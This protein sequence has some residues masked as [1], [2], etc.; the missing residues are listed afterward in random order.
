MGRIVDISSIKPVGSVDIQINQTKQAENPDGLMGVDQFL[1]DQEKSLYPSPAERLNQK[2]TIPPEDTSPVAGEYQHSLLYGKDPIFLGPNFTALSTADQS[3]LPQDVPNYIKWARTPDKAEEGFWKNLIPSAEKLPGRIFTSMFYDYPKEVKDDFMSWVEM[4]QK[5]EFQKL[6]TSQKIGAN[7]IAGRKTVGAVAKP[8]ADMIDGYL[9]SSGVYDV[10]NDTVTGKTIFMETQPDGSKSVAFALPEMKEFKQMWKSDPVGTA[11]LYMPFV[12]HTA[13]KKAALSKANA[14]D[15]ALKNAQAEEA[16]RQARETRQTGQNPVKMKNDIL[17]TQAKV[18]EDQG[19]FNPDYIEQTWSNLTGVPKDV[20]KGGESLVQNVAEVP[21]SVKTKRVTTKVKKA[22]EAVGVKVNTEFDLYRSFRDELEKAQSP[23]EVSIISDKYK[24]LMNAEDHETAL[25]HDEMDRTH[26]NKSLDQNL[27]KGEG[28]PLDASTVEDLDV[29]GFQV[30][31]DGPAEGLGHQLTIVPEGMSGADIIAQGRASTVYA[32]SFEDAKVKIDQKLKQ[33]NLADEV[34]NNDLDNVTGLKTPQV[35]VTKTTEGG[36]RIRVRKP[37]NQVPPEESNF[38]QDPIKTQENTQVIQDL[39]EKVKEDPDLYLASLINEANRWFHRHAGA[40]IE[41]TRRRLTDLAARVD[42]L[43][44]D[45]IDSEFPKMSEEEFDNSVLY[46][47][48]NTLNKDSNAYWTSDLNHAKLFTGIG[49][50]NGR[51][52]V[53]LKKD[54]HPDILN[55][56]TVNEGMEEYGRFAG[57]KPQLA[58]PEGY[59]P[60]RIWEVPVDEDPYSYLNSNDHYDPISRFDDYKATVKQAAQW[61]KRLK[62]PDEI[63]HTAEKPLT[64][65]EDL[66]QDFLDENP[67]KTREDIRYG[68]QRDIRFFMGADPLEAI[69]ILRRKY[70]RTKASTIPA[71]RTSESQIMKDIAQLYTGGK[72]D[73]DVTYSKGEIWRKVGLQPKHKFDMFPQTSD[74]IKAD[75]SKSIP[76]DSNSVESVFYDPPYLVKGG[77]SG[78]MTKRF[79]GFDSVDQLWQSVAGTIKEAARVLKPG[80]GYLVIKIQDVTTGG[81]QLTT[82]GTYFTTAEAYNFAIQ[83]GLRPVARHI[84][85][86]PN[87]MPLAPN[88]K[89]QKIPKKDFCDY[90]VFKK[91]AP[92]TKYSYPESGG[93]KLTSGADPTDLLTIGKYFKKVAEQKE[94]NAANFKAGAYGRIRRGL[95]RALIGKSANLTRDLMELHKD[96]GGYQAIQKMNLVVHATSRSAALADQLKGEVLSGLSKVQKEALNEV[97]FAARTRT[98]IDRDAMMKAKNSSYKTHKQPGNVSDREAW[99]GYIDDI[100][101][102]KGMTPEETAEVYRRSDMIFNI[103]RDQLRQ[104]H[105]AG[106]ID[107][108]TFNDLQHLDYSRRQIVD[109]IDPPLEG[110]GSSKIGARESGIQELKIGTE[111]ELLETD[112]IRLVEDLVIRTQNRIMH[113]NTAR[114]LYDIAKANPDSPIVRIPGKDTWQIGD[115]KMTTPGH[116]LAGWEPINVFIDGEKKKMYMPHEYASEFVNSSREISYELGKW[117]RIVSGSS[118]VRALATGVNVGFAVKNIFRDFAYMWIASQHYTPQTGWTSTYSTAAPKALGQMLVDLKEVG[119][120]VFM[121]EGI[122][123][124]WVNEGGLLD[125]LSDKDRI[126]KERFSKEKNPHMK[127]AIDALYYAGNTSELL[128]R[129]SLYNR[130]KK[131]LREADPKRSDASIREEAAYLSRD[132][133][134]FGDYGSFIKAADTVIPYLGA[135]IKATQGIFRSASRNPKE[136]ALKASQAIGLGATLYLINRSINPKAYNDVSRRDK[137]QNVILP[138][139][140]PYTGTDGKEH[141]FYFKLPKDQGQQLFMQLGEQGMR[142]MMGEETNGESIAASLKGLS[143]IQEVPVPPIMDALLGYITNKDFWTGADI[144]KGATVGMGVFDRSAEETMAGPNKPNPLASA[145]GQA[146][147]LS[148]DRLNAAAKAVTPKNW[149]TDSFGTVTRSVFDHAPDE[150]REMN[151]AEILSKYSIPLGLKEIVGTTDDMNSIKED[152]RNGEIQKNIERT[153]A[154]GQLDKLTEEVIKYKTKTPEDVYKFIDSQEDPKEADRLEQRYEKNKV[155]AQLLH[156]KQFRQMDGMSPEGAAYALHKMLQGRTPEEQK[157]L[158]DEFDEYCLVS[159]I[160]SDKFID[161]FNRLDEE[162]SGNGKASTR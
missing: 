69:G 3:D 74:T 31:Y 86:N 12:V 150:I 37:K 75:T 80:K 84:Y 79:G 120:D 102:T 95:N 131:K 138:F 89:V 73:V 1:Q 157:K 108:D 118:F 62:Q 81:N 162:G 19:F 133:M 42:E 139:Y 144:W 51:I 160:A 156:G 77:E 124:E 26:K 109:R 127:A 136:F 121:R 149:M 46:R 87:P 126:L 55:G 125:F 65:G 27:D 48:V 147:G 68:T 21:K 10:V 49:D 58:I 96:T 155:T 161:E 56:R 76:L 11:F 40:D 115:E 110:I 114:S 7:I 30:I 64:I 158:M 43:K 50:T 154:N 16:L 5:S 33:Y 97:V 141:H 23:E 18:A 36:K 34:K 38:Y 14:A 134:F 148:P 101:K 22:A 111:G 41:L 70:L 91:P 60:E 35:E 83:N 122:Y 142:W 94:I 78:M 32:K 128:G 29:P 93:V 99:Q 53:I 47:G 106:I 25:I 39:G 112:A 100:G 9:K 66:M 90:L 88:T 4:N 117:A 107:Y 113:N 98:V 59:E 104:L 151:T 103:A 24:S 152:L 52:R 8:I 72:F 140:M 135:T 82:K 130:A 61:A 20:W 137:E 57:K 2:R 28:K 6:N 44:Q 159:D 123:K 119:R 17:V 13:L 45:F 153:I 116:N 146:T 15:V 63:S 92:G 129:V 132:Y 145:V 67:G 143:P 85:V 71:T 54:V 105:E